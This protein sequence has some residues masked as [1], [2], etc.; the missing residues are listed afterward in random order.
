VVIALAH[1]SDL[2][3]GVHA[4]LAQIEAL[5]ALLPTLGVDAVVISGDVSQRARH[6]EFQAAHLFVRRARAHTP[7]LVIPGNHDVAWWRSPLGLFGE[8]PKYAKYRRYFGDDLHPV[9]AI[10]GAVITGA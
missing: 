10:P 1:L 7:A 9:L 6:G 2:H 4:D 3:F 8:R 5:D